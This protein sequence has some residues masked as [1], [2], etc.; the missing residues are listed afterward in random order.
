M[1]YSI[2]QPALRIMKKYVA[3]TLLLVISLSLSAQEV[4]KNKCTENVKLTFLNKEG[5]IRQ[6]KNHSSARDYLNIVV[7][8]DGLFYQNTPLRSANHLEDL[9]KKDSTL[10]KE[11]R[12]VIGIHGQAKFDRLTEIFCWLKQL[13]NYRATEVFIYHFDDL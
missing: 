13:N 12:V 8:K 1:L 11:F 7:N 6:L 3:L 5:A 10:F 4:Q 9:I 2:H